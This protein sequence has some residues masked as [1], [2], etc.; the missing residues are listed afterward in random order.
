LEP[1]QYGTNRWT[2]NGGV[3]RLFKLK[4][5]QTMEL[6]VE[7]TNVLN[8]TNFRN[9]SGNLTSTQFGRIQDANPARVMQFGLKYL[10]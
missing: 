2:L 6:R 8:H 5:R 9:P 7:G 4:E 3:S 1:R 10:F